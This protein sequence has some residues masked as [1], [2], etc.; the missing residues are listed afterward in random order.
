ML[1]VTSKLSNMASLRENIAR[2]ISFV[3]CGFVAFRAKLLM[4][5]NNVLTTYIIAHP[6]L[7]C[8]VHFV[9]C[10]LYIGS[11]VLGVVTTS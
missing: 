10:C 9:L 1:S 2:T 3:S 8:Q 4:C 5:V 6:I 7:S 11:V